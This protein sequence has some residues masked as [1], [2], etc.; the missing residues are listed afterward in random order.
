MVNANIP[1]PRSR[2]GNDSAR[3]IFD[4]RCAQAGLAMAMASGH[5]AS[6]FREATVSA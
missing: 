4:D 5:K 3:F 6:T 2:H 1:I